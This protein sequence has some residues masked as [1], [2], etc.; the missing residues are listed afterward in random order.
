[1]ESLAPYL[2][3]IGASTQEW[4]ATSRSA[5]SAA[6]RTP[7]AFEDSRARK[8]LLEI[9]AKLGA[10]GEQPV[11]KPEWMVVRAYTGPIYIK[12][13][14]VLRAA[15]TGDFE[16]LDLTLKGNR[17]PTTLHVLA[18]A[19]L[20]LGRLTTAR[21]I[22]RAPGGALPSNFWKRSSNGTIGFIEVGC[23]SASTDKQEALEYARRS[24]AGLVFELQLGFVG[25]GADCSWLSQYP[26]ERE[27]VLPPVSALEV[28]GSRIEGDMIIVT[29]KPSMMKP[30]HVRT[31]ANDLF[32]DQ[33][34]QQRHKALEA[35]SASMR[36]ARVA[37][38]F[39]QTGRQVSLR[40]SE[41]RL[42]WQKCLLEAELSS[43]MVIQ[44]VTKAR[45]AEA[46]YKL[47]SERLARAS[48]AAS[49]AKLS[50]D[51]EKANRDLDMCKQACIRAK[52]VA[53]KAQ[54]TEATAAKMLQ[55]TYST[56]GS[57]HL[58]RTR[59]Q[60][61]VEEH[62][63][64]GPKLDI[65]TNIRIGEEGVL[66]APSSKGVARE[67][68][69]RNISSNISLKH[70]G[71]LGELSL[72][73]ND[74]LD[75][76]TTSSALA[77]LE[78]LLEI[79]MADEVKP[80][81]KDHEKIEAIKPVA[82]I[83]KEWNVSMLVQA[84][85]AC[86]LACLTR[87]PKPYPRGFQRAA[88]EANCIALLV[89]SQKLLGSAFDQPVREAVL[90]MVKNDKD[91]TSKAIAAG[92]T[93]LSDANEISADTANGA[94]GTAAPATPSLQKEATPGATKRR[95]SSRGAPAA[96]GATHGATRQ[97]SST[98]RGKQQLV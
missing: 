75:S 27:I 1:M 35:T 2:K 78:R 24:K 12:Y 84:M 39:R 42:L 64:R 3:A 18:A 28:L 7:V 25:K 61:A 69:Q 31:G 97:T 95:G 8:K 77:A 83:L 59:T 53:Q 58:A 20:K 10:L 43:A 91:L 94:D 6:L 55:Y 80:K 45:L 79:L 65:V 72:V 4:P 93:W 67:K 87:S 30:P 89:N 5:D 15:L 92:M 70:L 85:G 38:A 22:Y 88:D 56:E 63:Q 17:Y 34:I 57:P 40:I 81:L 9:D 16:F 82:N 54:E 11:S 19:I 60:E 68:M 13:N 44:E 14:G 62:K 21:V 71:T 41:A 26:R 76:G 23:L 33:M 66:E 74:A 29:V 37:R 32:C 73:L 90:N 48:D 47:A 86:A 98:S 46:N 36:R 52:V 96:A 49:R 50:T 51:L